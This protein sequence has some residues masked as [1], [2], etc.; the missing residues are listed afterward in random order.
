MPIPFLQRYLELLKGSRLPSLYAQGTWRAAGGPS[1]EQWAMKP[2]GQEAAKVLGTYAGTA[3][4]VGSAG[5]GIKKLLDQHPDLH[6]RF[7]T[8][9]A[10]SKVGRL[11]NTMGI[12]VSQDLRSARQQQTAS[13]AGVLG[14]GLPSIGA[15]IGFQSIPE[16]KAREYLVRRLMALSRDKHKGFEPPGGEYAFNLF[17]KQLSSPRGIRSDP[18]YIAHEL[19]HAHDPLVA[20]MK[21]IPAAVSRVLYGLGSTGGVFG[22]A[23][24]PDQD[25]ARRAATIG[26]AMT[27]PT[28]AHEGYASIKGMQLLRQASRKI[29]LKVLLKTLSGIPTYG[30]IAAAPFTAYGIRKQ[31]GGFEQGQL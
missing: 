20:N 13:I 24:M 1:F 10:S 26:T 7:R 18:A 4:T 29:P 17:N 21:G 14:S 31:M 3:A 30:A 28:L 2:F 25:S 15:Q 16:M 27:L 22:A 11:M 23:S 19:G 6:E 5:Y 8:A 9:L 12:K